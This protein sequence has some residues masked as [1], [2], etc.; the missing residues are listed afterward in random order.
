MAEKLKAMEDSLKST[1]PIQT[2][3]PSP[4]HGP[5]CV[6]ITKGFHFFRGLFKVGVSEREILNVA[7]LEVKNEAWA[8]AKIAILRKLRRTLH[9][10]TKASF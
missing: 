3:H 2:A 4:W 8:D 7:V 5:S 1:Q 9:A 10:L 6:F